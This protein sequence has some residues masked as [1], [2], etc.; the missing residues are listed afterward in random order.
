MAMH[1]PMT[2]NENAMLTGYVEQQL[3]AVRGAAYGLTDEELWTTPT[4]SALSVG[5]IVKHVAR[6][7]Q[8]WLD[9][10]EA[11][12]GEPARG[13]DEEAAEEYGAD[14][15]RADTDT[16]DSLRAELTGALERA[17]QLLPQVDLGAKVPV[18]SDAPW[19]PADLDAW[20]VRWAVL[21]IVEE[22]AHHAGH[23]DII[24]ESIDGATMYELL[25]A[26][27]NWP[28][29]EWMKHWRRAEATAEAV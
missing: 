26:D 19:W 12:P 28:E 20:D 9:R 7:T 5:A 23:A 1:A 16:G 24:R 21:H 22:V 4:A 6:C 11:A 17:Q 3:L 27:Q 13:S 14:F 2:S 15:R 8:G 10:I 29:T 18:P 25:A